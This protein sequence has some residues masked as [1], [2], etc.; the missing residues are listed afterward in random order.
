MIP[1]N[2]LKARILAQLGDTHL[3]QSFNQLLRHNPETC[4]GDL[5]TCLDQLRDS[6]LIYCLN[7]HYA[8]T[9][10]GM[11]ASQAPLP[12]PEPVNSRRLW[13]LDQVGVETAI[14]REVS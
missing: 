5:Q 4:N 11:T 6:G 7:D 1:I 14:D 3:A 12:Q 2:L 13:H 8:L 9:C 10:Q